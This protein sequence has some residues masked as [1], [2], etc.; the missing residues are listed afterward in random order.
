MNYFP[1]SPSKRGARSLLL[2]SCAL[3]GLLLL[4][5][6]TLADDTAGQGVEPN[7]SPEVSE[8]LVKLPA[9]VLDRRIERDFR[10]SSLGTAVRQKE[11]DLRL[12]TQ[13]LA[14]ISAAIDLAEGESAQ[15]LQHRLLVEKQ[16]FIHQAGEKNT[17]QREQLQTKQRLL[18]R[19]LK[20]LTQADDAMSADRQKLIES[21]N[22]ARERLEKS[23]AMADKLLSTNP[24]VG[25]SRYAQ[26]YDE[27]RAA[28]DALREKIS[29]HPMNQDPMIDGE[30]LSKPDYVRHLVAVTE[31]ELA[32][33]DM[34]SEMLGFMAKLTSLDALAL[35]EQMDDPELADSDIP[36]A[37]SLTHAVNFFIN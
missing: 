31:G 34:E 1:T 15:E 11:E 20:K 26:E 16:A 33:L 12:K 3:S 2:A 8:Q 29:S 7:W 30:Q 36:T 19:I 18:E 25:E 37:D 14:D 5:T 10:D 22:A 17:M 27:K 28:L 13:T 32:L 23:I 21:Q 9:A 6:P 4:T 35:A 24:L